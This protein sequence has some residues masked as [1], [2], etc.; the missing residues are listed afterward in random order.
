MYGWFSF[1]FHFAFF[2]TS[3]LIIRINQIQLVCFGLSSTWTKYMC[4]DFLYHFFHSFV[5]KYF[6][7]ILSRK[8]TRKICVMKNFLLGLCEFRNLCNATSRQNTST[9]KK[10][11]NLSEYYVKIDKCNTQIL[12]K[13]CFPVVFL[14][15]SEQWFWFGFGKEFWLFLVTEKAYQF[16]LVFFYS[17]QKIFIIRRE[18][19]IL[20]FGCAKTNAIIE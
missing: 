12:V 16:Y 1:A 8:K 9:Q 15:W 4:C 7:F 3:N 17:D 10:T 6:S 20:L 13:K 11:S 5:W 19:N 2:Q 14:E 18:L